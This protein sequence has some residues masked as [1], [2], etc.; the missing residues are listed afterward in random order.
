MK[1]RRSDGWEVQ[2]DFD[3]FFSELHAE[4][5]L[6]PPPPSFT[7]FES[8]DEKVTAPLVARDEEISRFKQALVRTPPPKIVIVA[9]PKGAGKT[10]LVHRG[11]L[12]ALDPDSYA[13]V[14]VRCERRLWNRFGGPAGQRRS[15]KASLGLGSPGARGR[16]AEATRRGLPR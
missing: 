6:P 15:T 8:Y 7:V 1:E 10:S 5:L 2:L 14:L 3:T 9:G 16:R 12:P 4:L 11:I 13:G